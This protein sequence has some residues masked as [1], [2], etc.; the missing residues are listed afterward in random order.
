MA[1]ILETVTDNKNRTVAELRSQFT[2]LGGNLGDSGAVAWNFD[3]KGVITINTND[4][5]EDD[6]MEHVLE[7]GAEDMEY[8]ESSTRIISSME[9]F[10]ACNK[11]FQDK[12]LEVTEGKLEYIA[13]DVINITDVNHAK[14]VMKFIDHFEDH[15]DVQNVFTNADFDDSIIADLEN[16]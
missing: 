9:D 12:E 15:E 6:M 10:G 7:S 13:K 14:K 16:E 2:K 3:R 5:S 1:V 8:D 11:Y 4:I